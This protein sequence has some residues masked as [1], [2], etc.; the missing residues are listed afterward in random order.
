MRAP[1]SVIIPTLNAGKMLPVTVAALFEGLDSGLVREL[2]LSDGGSD[3]GIAALAQALG[4]HLITGAAGR[5]G[6]LRCGAGKAAGAWLL[7]LHADTVLEPGWSNEVIRHIA[8]RPNGA[9]AFRLSF[10]GAGIAPRFVAS[11]ANFRSRV[12][13]L[14][15]GDQGLLISRVLYDRVGGFQ[16]I[17]LMEDVALARAL[18]GRLHLLRTHAVTSGQKYESE[19]WLLKGTRNLWTLI[20]YFSGVSPHYLA[21]KYRR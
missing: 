11:W 3:D 9:A 14:P 13:G 18:R 8:T 7:F 17:P 15:Y 12:F 1:L 16:D 20:R 21:R 19:G 5:G 4:A 10:D 6:Q 2:I